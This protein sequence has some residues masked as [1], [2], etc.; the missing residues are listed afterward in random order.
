MTRL[1]VAAMMLIGM[2]ILTVRPADAQPVQYQFTPP[3]PITALPGTEAGSPPT[4]SA[5]PRA[6]SHPFVSNRRLHRFYPRRGGR[7]AIVPP[8]LHGQRSY[9]NRVQRCEQ[10]GAAAGVRPGHLGAFT[11]RCA[12]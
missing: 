3:P 8:A 7:V 12:G 5:G 9:S 1:A 11:N 6:Y 2:V 10:A 4:S